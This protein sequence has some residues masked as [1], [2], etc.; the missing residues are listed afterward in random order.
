MNGVITRRWWI[1]L[2]GL[3][4]L[5]IAG[6]SHGQGWT[7]PPLKVNTNF[8][9]KVEIS[10]IPQVAKP[11]APWYAY[12]PSDPRLVPSL[13]STPYPPWPAP[14]PPPNPSFDFKKDGPKKAE[15][16]PSPSGPRLTQ[17]WPSYNALSTSL[18]PVGFVP[19]QAPSY[20][21]QGR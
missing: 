3:A 13:Q 17:Y 19:A 4:W 2:V 8:Q 16:T 6:Q 5:G 7:R 11:T 1:G 15:V 20:W 21:Y 14:F 9:F 18:Q 12:F 10:T